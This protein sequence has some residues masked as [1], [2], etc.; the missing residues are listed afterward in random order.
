VS[1]HLIPRDIKFRLD[2]PLID[3]DGHWIVD[4][5]PVA[6]QR[7]ARE[8]RRRGVLAVSAPIRAAAE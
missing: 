6:H 3:G 2:H 5:A 1:A 7:F 4:T 8:R